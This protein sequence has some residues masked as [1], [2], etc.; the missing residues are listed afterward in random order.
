MQNVFKGV[1]VLAVVAG[2]AM[3]ADASIKQRVSVQPE[4]LGSPLAVRGT[5]GGGIGF[6]ASEGYALG[7]IAGQNGWLDNAPNASMR[8]DDGA[9]DGF[10]SPNA[11]HLSHGTQAQGAFGIAQAPATPG[12]TGLTVMTRIDDNGGANY[13]VRGLS[14]VGTSAFLSFRVEFDYGGNIFLQNPVT[15]TFADTGVPWVGNQW[16]PLSVSFGATSVSFTYGSTALGTTPLPTN[17]GYFDLAQFAH[18]NYQGFLGSTSFS[19]EPSA[20]YFDNVNAVPTPGALALLG[21][22]GLA[23]GRRRRA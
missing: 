13:F 7:N 10:A 22:G 4:L 8:V 2:A 1:A 12:A 5:P 17:G 3:S 19:G 9:N 18:D 20:G 15:G 16:N 14:V 23:A 11:L 6:E 21:L